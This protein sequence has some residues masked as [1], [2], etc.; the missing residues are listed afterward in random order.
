MPVPFLGFREALQKN[1]G[2]LPWSPRG[3]EDV[4][5][6]NPEKQGKDPEGRQPVL[7]TEE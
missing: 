1:M 4:N 5:L 6:I 3:Q 7:C 2:K